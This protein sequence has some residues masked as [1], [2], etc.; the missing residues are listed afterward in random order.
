MKEAFQNYLAEGRPCYV[1]SEFISVEETI[2]TIKK[3]NGFAVIAHPHL[4]WNK[5]IVNELLEMDFDGIE[6]YYAKLPKETEKPWE[7]IATKKNW[8][9]T[10]GSD[11]HG[12]VKP[13]IPLGC[14]WVY[15][16]TFKI[17]HDRFIS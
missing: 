15:E 16:K 3:G 14:S 4:I 12:A 8:L 17:L 1:R 10:G 13:D 6:V 7:N 2:D 9:M 5:N 11:F